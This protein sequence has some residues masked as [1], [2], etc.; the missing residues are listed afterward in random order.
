MNF[1]DVNSNWKLDLKVLCKT[2]DDLCTCIQLL[3]KCHGVEVLLSM[4]VMFTSAVTMITVITNNETKYPW[5]E[6]IRGIQVYVWFAIA[7][8]VDDEIREE[9]D[10]TETLL[11]KNLIDFR[12]NIAK[13]EA[14][15]TF[16]LVLSSNRLQFKAYNLYRLNYATLLG[17]VVT[18]MTYSILINKAYYSV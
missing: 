13:K 14:L 16:Q 12:C 3:Q 4:W 6:V 1:F 11:I 2:Y 10:M 9:V 15:Q 5:L 8:Y 18:V 7:C 17:T